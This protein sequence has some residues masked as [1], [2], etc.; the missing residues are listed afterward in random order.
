MSKHLAGL[1]ALAI[2]FACQGDVSN[3]GNSNPEKCWPSPDKPGVQVCERTAPVQIFEPPAG[4]PVINP[5]V[6]QRFEPL[7]PAFYKGKVTPADA[8]VNLGRMLYYDERLSKNGTMSCNT[9]HPLDKYGTTSDV[10]P[11]GVNGKRVARNA[12]SVYNAAGQFAQFWDGR[13]RNVEEQAMMPLLNPLEM[14]ATPVSVLATLNSVDGYQP[15]FKAAFPRDAKPI[16]LKNIGTAIGAFER[17]LTTPARWDRFLRGNDTSLSDKEK[18]GLRLFTSVG[19]QVCHTGELVGG[20][21][22]EKLGAAVAWQDSTD[23]GRGDITHDPAD[24]MMFKVPS[25]RNV[26]HTAPYFHD[27]SAKT[28]DEAVKQMAIYQTGQPLTDA[29]ISLVVAWLGSLSGEIDAK[30]IQPPILPGKHV[31]QAPPHD[32]S[33]G[34][35]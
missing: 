4:R 28:L 2:C 30:Y 29:E 25:L 3:N 34:T 10:T 7:R 18:E 32:T 11:L 8:L 13:S 15:L 20:T 24:D 5:R 14:A 22:Y 6:L 12:P 31:A 35:P 9:C 17:G 26:V 27:G 33:V 1:A 23:H 19:C 16:S 21:M